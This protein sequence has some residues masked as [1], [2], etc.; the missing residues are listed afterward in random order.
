YP[1][2]VSTI[3]RE[4]LLEFHANYFGPEGLVIAFAGG[5]ESEK[6]AALFEQIFSNWIVPSQEK[7]IDLPVWQPH[8]QAMRE[9]VV[10]PEKRQS[11]L[12]I[13]TSAPIGMSQEYQI[14]ALGNNILGQFGMMG[15]IGESVRERSG[16][17]YYSASTL[18][19]GLGP[20][21]WK[22]VAGVNPNNLDKAIRKIK[23][24]LS[25]FITEPVTREELEDVK[26]QA[27]GQLPISLESNS[28]I[29]RLLLSLERFQLS[30][31][32]LRELPAVLEAVTAEDILTCA[33]NYWHLDSLV[34]A[35]AGSTP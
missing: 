23:E 34:I 27:L 14:C 9:H 22:V 13:G 26:Q 8:R 30:M 7:Q 18:G 4:D 15:R 5:M 19:A 17:A 32:Y 28:G 21:T 35:S 31:D 6:T 2:T 20:T 11:D 29:A 12:I 16:L 24:E 3:C 33:R 25:R 1:Q 10:I